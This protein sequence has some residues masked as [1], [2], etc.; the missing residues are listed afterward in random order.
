[1]NLSIVGRI[2]YLA[3]PI[4]SK[5]GF[6]DSF[7]KVLKDLRARLIIKFDNEDVY[8]HL[9]N[10]P[11]LLISNHPF[12]FGIVALIASLPNRNNSYL[13]IRIIMIPECC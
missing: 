7:R 4:A 9:K 10:D 11:V 6:S 1:M 12:M 3:N 8:E 5:L 2:F 13:I